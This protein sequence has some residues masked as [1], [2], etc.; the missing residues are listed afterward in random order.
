MDQLKNKKILITAGPTWVPIDEVRVIT[1]I[2][3]GTLGSIIAK[4]AAK[5]KAK[6]TLLLGSEPVNFSLKTS[7]NLRIIRFKFF[8]ELFRLM[9]KEISSQRY[10]AVIHSAAVADYAP[11][12]SYCGKIK[13]GR[14]NLM[15]KLKPTIKIV[16]KIK[17]W[18]P[19]IFLVKFKV[20][21]NLQKKKLI[22]RSFKSMILSSADLM[23]ANDLKDMTEKGHKAFII[24]TNKK[25]IP[26]NQK[27]EIAN[28]I[29]DVI[30]KR[31]P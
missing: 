8:K 2:F 4:E 6:A 19:S 12:K 5:R 30:A 11:Q 24:D 27:K 21:F 22:D 31:L 16:D 17:K 23:V 25:I 26:C 3:K 13:S 10:D 7:R 9:K 15:I 28:N 1:N 14:D 18:D 20:E 29:L